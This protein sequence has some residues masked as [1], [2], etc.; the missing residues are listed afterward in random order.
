[1]SSA[2]DPSDAGLDAEAMLAAAHHTTG[3]SDWGDDTLPQRFS[4]VV[5][6][7]NGL[8][9]DAHGARQAAEVCQTL[10][11]TRLEFFADRRRHPLA[12]EVIDRPLFVTGEPRSGTTLLHALLAEDDRSRALRFWEVMYPAP[13]PGWDRPGP[14]ACTALG[15][16]SG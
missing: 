12:D 8:R 7:L 11:T 5:D 2:P 3:L 13:P 16:R 1:M 14:G 10:L 4:D 9:L 6:Q 15:R